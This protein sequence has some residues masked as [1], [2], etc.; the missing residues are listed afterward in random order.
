MVVLAELALADLASSA[1]LLVLRGGR[2]QEHVASGADIGR[3]R[4]LLYSVSK[5][6]TAMAV[7]RLVDGKKLSL[8][9][10]IATVIPE[11]G[12][13][14]KEDLT[15][16]ELLSHSAGI[17]GSEGLAGD[18]RPIDITDCAD[19][20]QSVELVC[21]MPL[22]PDLRGTGIYHGLTFGFLAAVVER[23]SGRD[24]RSFCD[25]EVFGRL[26]MGSTTWGLPLEL[27]SYA[28]GF[29]GPDSQMWR[30]NIRQDVMF[31][32]GGAWSTAGDVARLLLMLREQGNV[33][34]KPFLSSG[35]VQAACTPRVPARVYGPEGTI[36]SRTWSYGLGLLID[37]ITPVF[38]RGSWTVPGTFG[39][40]GATRTRHFT[41]QK[42]TLYLSA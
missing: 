25:A 35:L 19:W 26:A 38:A 1:E 22:Q 31:P 13:A 39:H 30:S 3:T 20:D 29:H 37:D 27:N 5:M 17:P 16:E 18:S 9:T 24:F 28:A 40:S 23:V 42:Q 8:A 36:S 6:I 2:V 33:D 7:L 15:V 41:I 32:A 4:F 14:S 11:F 21:Q 10:R 34:G 12:Q